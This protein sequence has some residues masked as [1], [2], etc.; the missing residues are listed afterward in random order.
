MR[1]T[2]VNQKKSRIAGLLVDLWWPAAR[3]KPA[4]FTKFASNHAGDNSPSQVPAV[5]PSVKRGSKNII[6]LTT[7]QVGY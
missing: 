3:T 4:W 6:G 5:F 2:N 1:C 7:P